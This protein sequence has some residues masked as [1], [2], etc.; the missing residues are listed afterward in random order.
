MGRAGMPEPGRFTGFMKGSRANQEGAGADAA[1]ALIAGLGCGAAGAGLGC[2]AA[3]SEA[4]AGGAADALA[5]AIG[6]ERRFAGA[7]SGV[8]PSAASSG[9]TGPALPSHGMGD[10][11]SSPRRG[12]CGVFGVRA[13]H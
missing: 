6:N 8:D 11:N 7:G 13:V 9:A 4:G 5:L 1:L 12:P 10:G 2:G 3:G